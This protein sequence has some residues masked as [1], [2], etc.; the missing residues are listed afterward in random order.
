MSKLFGI[1]KEKMIGMVSEAHSID[2]NAVHGQQLYD[3]QSQYYSK[4]MILDR[5][6]IQLLQAV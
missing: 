1:W 2:Y 3:S 5:Y 4:L 6:Q